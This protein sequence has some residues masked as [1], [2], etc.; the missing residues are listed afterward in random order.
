[1]SNGNNNN[2]EER[3]QPWW[4]PS[5]F[6][7]IFG[8]ALSLVLIGLLCYVAGKTFGMM[9]VLPQAVNVGNATQVVDTY[10]RSKDLLTTLFPLFG[11]VVTFWLGVAVEGKRADQNQDTADRATRNLR[12]GAGE[13]GEA[14]GFADSR[15]EDIQARV[16]KGKGAPLTDAEMKGYL[17][18][19][20]QRLD[21][22]QKRLMGRRETSKREQQS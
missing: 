22:A 2:G 10:A 4:Q 21:K 15:L 8:G 7:E 17:E 20:V 18:G 6:K 11:A 14:R 16:T 9:D 12:A 1:M 13:L 5:S 19:I 3:K